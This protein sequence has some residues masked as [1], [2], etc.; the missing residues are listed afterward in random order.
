MEEEEKEQVLALADDL[1]EVVDVMA[2]EDVKS[3]DVDVEIKELME[4]CEEIRK[5]RKNLERL[6]ENEL[7]QKEKRSKE[8]LKQE[9]DASITS[10][11]DSIQ[12]LTQ[13]IET[14]DK[15]IKVF[16]QQ[17]RESGLQHKKKASIKSQ[18]ENAKESLQN[19][20]ESR[21]MLR[22]QSDQTTREQKEVVQKLQEMEKASATEGESVLH[23]SWE[24]LSQKIIDQRRRLWERLYGEKGAGLEDIYDTL[25]AWNKQEF[26]QRKQADN[27]EKIRIA[28]Q[29][30]YYVMFLYPKMS[31]LSDSQ[32]TFAEEDILKGMSCLLHTFGNTVVGE[33]IRRDIVKLLEMYERMHIPTEYLLFQEYVLESDR[34]SV[35]DIKVFESKLNSE[36]KEIEELYSAELDKLEPNDECE[37]NK[38]TSSSTYVD[39]SGWEAE[40]KEIKQKYRDLYQTVVKKRAKKENKEPQEV[41]NMLLKLDSLEQ[42]GWSWLDVASRGVVVTLRFKDSKVLYLTAVSYGNNDRWIVCSSLGE[43]VARYLQYQ[44]SWDWWKIVRAIIGLGGLFVEPIANFLQINDMTGTLS[45]WEVRERFRQSFP[46]IAKKFP[47]MSV[48]DAVKYMQDFYGVYAKE[49]SSGLLLDRGKLF[50][51][52]DMMTT[53]MDMHD[54][55]KVQELNKRIEEWEYMFEDP[56]FAME[57][58]EVDY[59][60]HKELGKEPFFSHL[61]DGKLELEKNLKERFDIAKKEGDIETGTRIQLHFI[62]TDQIA[63]GLELLEGMQSVQVRHELYKDW[64]SQ[65]KAM[66]GVLDDTMLDAFVKYEEKALEY[67]K[68]NRVEYTLSE[69]ERERYSQ[70][71]KSLDLHYQEK[72]FYFN[73]YL[74]DGA[75][76]EKLTGLSKKSNLVPMTDDALT[77]EFLKNIGGVLEKFRKSRSHFLHHSKGTFALFLYEM[78]RLDM[79]MTS[80]NAKN[81]LYKK[82]CLLGER[83]VL[84]GKP[85]VSLEEIKKM[86][87]PFWPYGSW[88][89]SYF[90]YISTNPLEY[91][92]NINVNDFSSLFF[93]T[94]MMWLFVENIHQGSSKKEKEYSHLTQEMLQEWHKDFPDY[95]TLKYLHRERDKLFLF[96]R[97]QEFFEK[98]ILY[99]S[100]PDNFFSNNTEFVQSSLGLF[101]IFLNGLNKQRELYEL[102]LRLDGMG[103]FAGINWNIDAY[104]AWAHLRSLW[105][106]EIGGN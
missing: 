86:L 103:R 105:E 6:Q 3:H 11:G 92:K 27:R 29:K 51:M 20:K 10:L 79:E 21:V 36:R 39:Q 17:S 9:L 83:G 40:Y 56:F 26:W 12:K 57:I 94:N 35:G 80:S 95:E 55:A 2:P 62:K 97:E 48:E 75:L 102:F 84:P 33:D 53:Y 64:L 49:K 81:L 47:A 31:N 24:G 34:A 76:I 45:P 90:K 104:N 58:L 72:D 1:M 52:F 87:F 89:D 28:L 25:N 42:E 61:Q 101:F 37:P 100:V 30:M 99:L 74:S 91:L 16:Q 4:L 23:E 68:K 50:L 73:P 93:G 22:R 98:S 41:F 96:S 32:K 5:T 15:E 82:Y 14:T 78:I 8:S 88:I 38:V 63:Q 66:G 69:E 19:C 106:K 59:K 85:P 70:F 65:S 77:K 46:L 43:A 7:F 71:W 13:Q 60:L 67:E 18:M 44:K 54:W